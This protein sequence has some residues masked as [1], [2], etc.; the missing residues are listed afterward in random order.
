MP[1]LL[2][3]LRTDLTEIVSKDLRCSTTVAPM[4]DRNCLLG[5]LYA[6]IHSGELWVVPVGNFPGK[7]LR[8]DRWR[9]LQ[10]ARALGQVI[11]QHYGSDDRGKVQN[12]SSFGG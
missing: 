11:D 12:L 3:P 4:H 9:E 7:Y 5:K 6:R 8:N 10:T 2:F 1:D